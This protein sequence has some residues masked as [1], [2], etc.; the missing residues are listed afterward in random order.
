MHIISKFHDYYDRAMQ[1]GQD[2][3]RPFL[4]NQDAYDVSRTSSR[5]VPVPAYLEAVLAELRPAMPAL[6]EYRKGNE[7]LIVRPGVVLFAGVLYPCAALERQ[8]FNIHN[9]LLYPAS[10]SQPTP[11]WR[12]VYSGDELQSLLVQWEERPKSP[13]PAWRATRHG[14]WE[15][16]MALRG[17][18]KWHGWAQEHHC[19]ILSVGGS[20]LTIAVNPELH[21]LQFYRVFTPEQAYQE[22]DMFLGGLAAPER[23]TVV[24]EDKYRIPQ[25]G[26]D[27]QSFRKDPS[28]TRAEKRAA[29]A[30][31]PARSDSLT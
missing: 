3:G 16:F 27:A 19:A 18:K 29:R 2:L 23:N 31:K 5:A 15:S 22:L 12:L 1:H 30:A 13:L 14:D 25:H 8:P 7:R 24:I 21:A 9:G 28:P 11:T 4:R 17:S 26:F 10:L 20:P 6:A